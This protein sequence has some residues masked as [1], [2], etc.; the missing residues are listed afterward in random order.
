MRQPS[1]YPGGSVSNT[2][3]FLVGFLS[4]GAHLTRLAL[5]LPF[6]EMKDNS[7]AFFHFGR[8]EHVEIR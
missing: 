5:V 4:G 3:T 1:R 7:T 2:G 8:G 6:E